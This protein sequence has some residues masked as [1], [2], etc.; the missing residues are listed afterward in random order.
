L[1]GFFVFL[2]D[3]DDTHFP[4]VIHPTAPVL[5]AVLAVAEAEGNCSQRK[6]V[7]AFAIGAEVACR[8]GMSVHPWHYDDGWH[9]TSKFSRGMN[10]NKS[11]NVTLTVLLRKLRPKNR[12]MLMCLMT[13]F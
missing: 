2:K 10:N 9:I 13:V 11:A 1:K 8:I 7:E 4:T 12:K 5:P 3:Y 6:V